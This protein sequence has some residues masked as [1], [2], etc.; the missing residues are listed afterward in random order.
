MVAPTVVWFRRDLRVHD[1][2]PLR[3][4]AAHGPVLPLFILDP[5]LLHHP[6]TG[7]ARVDFLLRSLRALDH[8]LKTRGSGLTV[9]IGEPSAVLAELVREIGASTVMVHSDCERLVG[10]VRDA[11]VA[12]RLGPLGV[13]LR[14]FDP[15]GSTPDLL[16][17][18]HWRRLWIASMAMPILEAPARL[19]PP[20]QSPQGATRI[21]SLSALGLPPSD[22]PQPEAGT[23]AARERLRSFL[24][25]GASETYYWQ[26][27]EPAARVSSGLSPYLKFGVISPREVVQRLRG[28]AHA[29]TGPRARRSVG[30]LLSRLRW[31][32]SMHQRF[33]YLPQLE[34]CS[35]WSVFDAGGDPSELE[36]PLDEALYAAWREGRT[37]YPI[38][39][40]AARCLLA[41]GGWR[42]LNFRARA[43]HS[44][45]L[46][47]LCGIDW[48][49]GALHYM[50]HLIDGDCAIDHYQWAMQAGVT[51]GRP[52]GWSRIYHPGQTAVTRCD[53]H[54][55]FIR[56][57]V[58]EVAHLT[59]DQLGE[60]PPLDGYPAPIVRYEQCR[61]RREQWL[62]ERRAGIPGH[63]VGQ[64]AR[65]P[66]SLRPFAAERFPHAV[67]D[68]SEAPG[69]ALHPPALP[70]DGLTPEEERA[71]LSW[72]PGN[73]NR[74][75]R[76]RPPARPA[77]RS[78]RRA[79]APGQLDLF[80]L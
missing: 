67:V 41:E 38:V 27:S 12:E 40:A 5:A 46:S 70:L 24:E 65:L 59:N 61:E 29:H 4:A 43:I 33:R 77:R 54:G 7:P 6:E 62:L 50:R 9:R 26:L 16:S 56:R 74:V 63:G 48:R 1:H 11:R 8:D 22:V 36:A 73:R 34:L 72:F 76:R 31:A 20:P 78:S 32:A 58:P 14:W 28:S 3:E 25:D 49:Y 17:H 15:P 64:L 53:P 51:D 13:R 42:S 44:S 30:Q 71:L 2:A 39:D 52:G 75:S 19:P 23:D 79:P 10:R 57:W 37:G 55:L 21:P 69:Q 18:S 45:F 35:L 47:N 66:Q 80:A 68:W 60:P